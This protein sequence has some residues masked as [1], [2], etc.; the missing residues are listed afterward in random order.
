MQECNQRN[1]HELIECINSSMITHARE[2]AKEID[3]TAVLVYVDVI[4]SERNLK[5]LI[6]EGRCILAARSQKVIEN[7]ERNNTFTT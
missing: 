6:R 3:A 2:I 7:L 1:P 5:S 4:K